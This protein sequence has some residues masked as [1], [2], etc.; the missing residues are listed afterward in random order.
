VHVADPMEESVLVA[1][2]RS[3]PWTVQ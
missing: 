1:E 2:G 3:Y